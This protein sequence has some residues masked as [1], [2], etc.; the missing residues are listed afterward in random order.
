MIWVLVKMLDNQNGNTNNTTQ[1]VSST[2]VSLHCYSA[3]IQQ[4]RSAND[5]TCWPKKIFLCMC[6]YDCLVYGAFN[7]IFSSCLLCHCFLVKIKHLRTVYLSSCGI[8]R[9]FHVKEVHFL[10]LLWYSPL[11]RS[12]LMERV[13]C[14]GLR[15]NTLGS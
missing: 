14:F 5:H 3:L 11:T 13:R 9:V 4:L 7:C 1:L 15:R 2:A 10:A 8:E 12:S 6:N